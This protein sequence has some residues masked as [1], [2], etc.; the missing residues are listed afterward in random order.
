[1]R[2]RLI[3]LIGKAKTDDLKLGTFHALSARYLRIHGKLIGLDPNFTICDAEER[4]MTNCSISLF[5]DD[6][7]QQENH[8][9]PTQ[10]V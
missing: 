5:L 6:S 10:R 7:L 2:E 9:A 4:Y 3:Q 1:M 8:W